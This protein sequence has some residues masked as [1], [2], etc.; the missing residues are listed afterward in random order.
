MKPGNVLYLKMMK[1]NSSQFEIKTKM[2]DFGMCNQIGGTP[3]W[4]PPNFTY[5]RQP[6]HSDEYSFGLLALYLLAEDDE[7]FYAMRD[8][9][10]ESTNN[11]QWLLHFRALPE[12]QII[13]RMLD[14][15]YKQTSKPDWARLGS[16][17]Q[18]ITIQ[19]LIS[20][21]VPYDYLTLQDG[22][23]VTDKNE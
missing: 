1:N 4:S 15:N 17:I 21:G 11:P 23:T 16:N 14:T 12:I 9:R 7:L 19:R 3:G 6:G 8:N 18:R 20:L 5:T 10:I 2:A 22:N 13:R